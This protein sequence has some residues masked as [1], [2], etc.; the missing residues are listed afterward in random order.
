MDNE[1][2]RKETSDR[3]RRIADAM[4]KGK[5]TVVM[6]SISGDPNDTGPEAGVSFTIAGSHN[7]VLLVGFAEL[8]KVRI[9]AVAD[10]YLREDDLPK[11]TKH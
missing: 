11:S 5:M 6:V 4:E 8:L 1:K 2:Q 7:P 9:T 3:L 10:A